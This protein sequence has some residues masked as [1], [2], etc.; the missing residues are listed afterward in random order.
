MRGI[1]IVL[2]CILYF[3]VL[4][5]LYRIALHS[6]HYSITLH[7]NLVLWYIIL[8]YVIAKFS[9]QDSLLLIHLRVSTPIYPVWI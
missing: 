5:S 6:V 4:C 1:S 2:Y 7:Y 8:Y 3:I 9:E